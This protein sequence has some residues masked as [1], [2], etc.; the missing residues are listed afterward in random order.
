VDLTTPRNAKSFASVAELVKII[1]RNSA[2]IAFATTSRERST[3][4][5]ASCP[6]E[7]S[8][9]AFPNLSEKYG[10]MARKTAGST[11]VVAA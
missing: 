1:S 11:G 3:A 5:I 7:W 2:P 6:N 4:A 10:F 9:P 8:E